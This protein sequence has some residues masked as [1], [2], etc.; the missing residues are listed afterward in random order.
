MVGRKDRVMIA[1]ASAIAGFTAEL[2]QNTHFILY[3]PATLMY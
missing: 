1:A 2:I 3:R